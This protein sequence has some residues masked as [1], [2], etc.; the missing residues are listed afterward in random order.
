ML[1]ENIVRKATCPRIHH[2][3]EAW[4]IPE[5]GVDTCGFTGT[6]WWADYSLLKCN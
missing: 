1:K 5:S 4:Q 2:G 3:F 6:Y